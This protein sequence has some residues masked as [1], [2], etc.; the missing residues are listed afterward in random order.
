LLSF[1]EL[2][3]RRWYPAWRTNMDFDATFF[4]QRVRCPVLLLLGGSDP[5]I[6]AAKAA[7]QIPEALRKGGNVEIMVRVFP[8]AEHG[9]AVW[10]LPGRMPPPRF[11][12][13]Y[14]SLMVDWGL[15]V[16]SRSRAARPGG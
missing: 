9:L 12:D 7:T 1:D 6:D 14:P 10:W 15:N 13:G 3:K 16:L 11:P 4:W 5:K 2:T 8:R